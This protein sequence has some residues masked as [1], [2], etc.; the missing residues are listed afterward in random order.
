PDYI[1]SSVVINRFV[2]VTRIT[3]FN[4]PGAVTVVPTSAFAGVIS[5]RTIVQADQRVISQTRPVVDPVAGP[6][7]RPAALAT[8]AARPTVQVPAVVAQQAFNRPVVASDPPALP[9]VIANANVAQS[10]QVQAVP[11]A[12]VKQK[13]R[14]DNSGEV[15]AARQPNGLPVQPA[16]IGGQQGQHAMGNQVA[17]DQQ[18]Q[19][20]IQ[21]L[22]QRAAQGDRAAGREMRQLQDQQRIDDKMARRAANQQAAAQEQAPQQQ[23]IQQAKAQRAEQQA[24]QN[25]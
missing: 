6:S 8:V 17:I 25:A 15:V 11:K 24:T 12:N 5:P 3:N 10:L 7:V 13:L 22:A 4:V 20:Q 2:N 23:A 21:A 19:A 16:R 1:G 9:K 18:R 14:L